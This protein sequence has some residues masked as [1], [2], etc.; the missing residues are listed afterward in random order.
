MVLFIS[1][2]P[3][4]LDGLDEIKFKVKTH[5]D[6]PL[7]CNVSGVPP[8]QIIWV[9]A[10]VANVSHNQPYV[11]LHENNKTLVSTFLY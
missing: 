2:P 1:V 7:F 10:N 3:T 11:K 4:K 8:P 6:L 9:N 5:T